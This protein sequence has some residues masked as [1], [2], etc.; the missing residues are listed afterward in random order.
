MGEIRWV[1]STQL[2]LKKPG[3]DE[4]AVAFEGWLV[5]LKYEGRESSMLMLSNEPVM[6]SCV[7]TNMFTVTSFVLSSFPSLH[8]RY[9]LGKFLWGG[10]CDNGSYSL[11]ACLRYSGLLIVPWE[12]P[13]FASFY[14]L[15]SVLRQPSIFNCSLSDNR[16]IKTTL[17]IPP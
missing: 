6:H 9:S 12:S 17:P 8:R 16:L 4:V 11:S 15:L 13:P 14:R 3:A 10:G 5:E 1:L 2:L 7:S